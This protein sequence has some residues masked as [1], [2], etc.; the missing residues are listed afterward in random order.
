MTPRER[1]YQ[2]QNYTTTS[3]ISL[4][5]FDVSVSIWIVNTMSMILVLNKA[6][7]FVYC[8]STC[9]QTICHKVIVMNGKIIWNDNNLLTFWGFKKA[10]FSWNCHLSFSI[11]VVTRW[12]SR[13]DKLP[14]NLATYL[15]TK[16]YELAARYVHVAKYQ[17]HNV[18]SEIPEYHNKQIHLFIFR[19]NQCLH[20][21]ES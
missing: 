6:W 4:D 15:T 2:V 16:L 7:Y 11:K 3:R 18:L 20:K 9:F 19:I 5:V 21:G 12:Q 13:L 14:L 1:V 17:D 10:F 8:N